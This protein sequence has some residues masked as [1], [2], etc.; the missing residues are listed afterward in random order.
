[1]SIIGIQLAKIT[2][3]HIIFFLSALFAGRLYSTKIPST[4][5]CYRLAWP[6]GHSAAGRIRSIKNLIILSGIEQ[7]IINTE[8]NDVYF[9][10]IH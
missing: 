10:V 2:C 7:A 8:F 3:K 4:H 5:F 9:Y 1:M 6:Q